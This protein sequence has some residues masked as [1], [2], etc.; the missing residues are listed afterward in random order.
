LLSSLSSLFINPA[1]AYIDTLVLPQSQYSASGCK[2]AFSAEG[3]MQPLVGKQWPGGYAFKPFTIEASDIEF[4]YSKR[5]VQA[6]SSSISASNLATAWSL[7]GVEETLIGGV[8]QGRK[9]FDIRGASQTSK[10][11]MWVAASELATRLGDSTAALQRHLD[12]T[13]YREVK[14]GPLLV[15]RWTVKAEVRK[16]ALVGW[17]RNEGGSDFSINHTT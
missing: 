14:D 8:L 12:V 16:E 17:I 1:H 7:S 4:K 3:R 9:A 5:S 2:R 6:R 11:Q 15:D 13:T 10:R